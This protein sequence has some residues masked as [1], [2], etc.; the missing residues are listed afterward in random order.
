MQRII[1]KTAILTLSLMF[2]VGFAGMA[3]GFIC[4]WIS[5]AGVRF[6]SSRIRFPLNICSFDVADQGEVV[7]FSNVHNRIQVFSKDGQF[8]RGWFVDNAGFTAGK[9]LIA[10]NNL[11]HFA[12]PDDRHFT[13]DFY[14]NIIEDSYEEGILDDIIKRKDSK[15]NQ[16]YDNC[17]YKIKGGIR[18]TRIVKINPEDYE[19]AVVSEPFY[20]WLFGQ[21]FPS[22][23][24]LFFPLSILCRKQVMQSRKKD[25]Q[26]S[27]NNNSPKNAED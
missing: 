24:F 5:N 8:S 19:S 26:V 11:I 21:W 10:P 17:F 14:G 23:V 18:G 13:F 12:T 7:C 20:L 2:L 9:V 15:I 3:S 1:V 25:K 4:S 6:I 27:T 22:W 16:L